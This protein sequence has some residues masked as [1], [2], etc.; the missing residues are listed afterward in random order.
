MKLTFFSRYAETAALN[1]GKEGAILVC[2]KEIQ[3]LILLWLSW[4]N[5]FTH[6]RRI[7]HATNPSD[8]IAKNTCIAY[9]W[10]FE[11]A[12]INYIYQ[13]F[14]TSTTAKQALIVYRWLSSRLAM[15][16]SAPWKITLEHKNMEVWKTMLLFNWVIF[17]FYDNFQRLQAWAYLALKSN[18]LISNWPHA[19]IESTAPTYWY[20]NNN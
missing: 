19:D 3:H 20:K 15:I 8:M 14:E 11:F 12:N 6:R 9:N 2:G 16:D 18:S 17:T 13:L 10:R 7:L 5:S 1:C 4:F